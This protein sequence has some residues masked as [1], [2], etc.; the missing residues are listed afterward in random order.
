MIFWFSGTPEMRRP[1]EGQMCLES[2]QKVLFMSKDMDVA[3]AKP[4]TKINLKYQIFELF[5][6]KL[7]QNTNLPQP[8]VHLS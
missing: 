4:F 7:I 5:T 1:A 8:C 6:R 2:K 3:E